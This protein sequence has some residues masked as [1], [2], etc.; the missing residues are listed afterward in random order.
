[1]FLSRHRLKAKAPN[2]E[3][4]LVTVDPS[5]DGGE[6]ETGRHSVNHGARCRNAKSVFGQD[7]RFSEKGPAYECV[8]P[9][10]LSAH[11]GE[12]LQY[13]LTPPSFTT[14]A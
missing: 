13:I 9:G 12:L 6:T 3:T 8:D 14:E 10:Y 1:M 2:L 5:R 4:V 7:T 11:Q